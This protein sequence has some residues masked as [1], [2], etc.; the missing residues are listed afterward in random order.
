M[1][2]FFITYFNQHITTYYSYTMADSKE[3]LFSE[4]P[5]VSTQEWMDKVTVDL[6]GADFEKRLV[7]K[8]NEGFKV[9]PFYR[10]E[11]L[12][13]IKTTDSLPGE[14]PYVRGT[15][16][17]NNWFVRQDI[18]VT[19]PK[20]ANEKALEILN[21]GITSLGFNF[22]GK[23]FTAESMKSLLK[24]IQLDCIEINF[25]NCYSEAVKIT[26]L[27]V[28]YVKTYNFAPEKIKASINFDPFK[29]MMVKGL[30]IDIDLKVTLKELLEA[31]E[32]LPKLKVFG[33]NPYLF[34]NAG[35]YCAQELGFG[36]A[37]GNEYLTLATEA[38]LSAEKV[39]RKIKF[40]FGIGT[41]YFM[42]IAKFRAGRLLWA[43][44]VNAYL[45]ADACKGAAKMDVHAITSEWNQSVYDAYV[46]LLRSQTETMSASIAGVDS[47]SVTPFDNAYKASDDFS[48][49]I[50]RN[51]QLLLK[52]EAHF[53][54]V[55][56]ASA[57]SYYIENL[58]ASIAEQAWKIFLSVDEK[59]GFYA[60]LKEGFIQN[61][62]NASNE[63]R[64]K[65]ISSRREILLGTNQF[66]N[67]NEFSLEKVEAGKKECTCCCN[68]EKGS[69]ATLKFDRGSSAFDTLRLATE[70]SGKRPKVFMLTIGHLNMRLARAQFSGNFFGCAGYELIDNLGFE[71][72]EEGV[73]AALAAKADIIVICSSDDEYAE[74]A[75]KAFEAIG[76][77]A[78]FVVAGAP[79]CTEDLKAIGINN[80]INVRTNV[81][82]TLQGFNK[83]LGIN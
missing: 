76:G 66:P 48:E 78:I 41:N 28:D 80:F 63:K 40:N 11:D 61:E 68:R 24:G 58:T 36:L 57:G 54:K 67:F 55:V 14:F 44:I 20:K 52:E 6:K 1:C 21:K 18:D 72:P 49:R 10:A 43:Q 2:L 5:P 46:N 65:D 56:D 13:G 7:W 25:R 51:Q 64:L 62:V 47:I 75:P 45:P 32:A 9:K 35:A 23:D 30:E 50:S 3:K 8:T 77:K 22:S 53:D 73:A 17:N 79:A 71:T 60:A 26:K 74:L 70:Q 82:E 15:K 37:Y 42:E 4:F 31:S 16:T 39:A 33:A 38:G 69:I 29:R 81:L 34:N 83:Q 19:D 27:F 59:G 12:E